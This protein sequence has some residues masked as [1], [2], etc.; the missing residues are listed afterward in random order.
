MAIPNK[1]IKPDLYN[2]DKRFFYEKNL[3]NHW[4]LREIKK[5]LQNKDE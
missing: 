3:E 4:I 1:N 5:L 2:K